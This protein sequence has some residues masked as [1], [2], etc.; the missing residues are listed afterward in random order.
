VKSERPG[1]SPRGRRGRRPADGRPSQPGSGA[2]ARSGGQR[3][4]RG[5]DERPG[6][7]AQGASARGGG[8]RPTRSGGQGGYQR[9]G[10]SN[11]TGWTTV[12]PWRPPRDDAD[13]PMLDE[14]DAQ[15]NWDALPADRSSRRP[16]GT[17]IGAG[18][19]AAGRSGSRP[20]A[21]PG[22]GQQPRQRAPAP[23]RAAGTGEPASSQKRRGNAPNTRRTQGP[24]AGG[25]RR[26]GTWLPTDSA[27]VDEEE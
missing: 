3:R 26:T 7:G 20:P 11:T 8:A 2:P 19:P 16:A 15:P 23:S 24:S 5:P 18:R 25:Q 14:D 4:Q 27:P 12:R 22:R 9:R 1:N 6:R 21:W 10:P 13:V 17:S